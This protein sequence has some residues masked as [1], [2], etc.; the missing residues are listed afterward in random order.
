MHRRAY[1]TLIGVSAMMGLLAVL[2]AL[3]LD[4]RLVDPDGFLGPSWLRLPALVIGAFLADVV[5]RMVWVSRFQPKL[6]RGIAEDRIREHWTRERIT[7]VV[8]GLV[9][10][11][12]TYV[13]YR[14][15]KSFLPFVTTRTF[16]R[17]LHLLDQAL[18]FGREPAIV[19]HA[20]L[21]EGIV[22][23]ALSFIYLWFLP[24]VP[25]TLAAWLVW[26]RNISYGYWFVTAQVLAWTLGTA[27]YY[28]LPTLGPGF[29]YLWLYRDLSET[30][31]TTLM[32]SLWRGRLGVRLQDVSSAVQ[33]VAGF[34][35]LHTAITL[36]F[37]LMAQYTIRSRPV[38][39]ILWVN[40]GVTI[41]AT[42]YFGW[43]YIADDIGGVAIALVSFYLGGIATG[44]NFDRHGLASH[45]TTDSSVVPIDED[46]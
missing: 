14:N 34:A 16:D 21:G 31:T 23:H 43:H 15:L 4:K 36:L 22:A 27:S 42:L 37:A 6:M 41:L 18:F 29:E 2:T 35:S 40:F 9:C 19:L 8:L 13:S 1:A 30:G 12:V 44:Q 17:E 10:F 39:W 25:I 33:S 32:D 7:L 24:L 45:P 38:H 11:Y 20:V 3:A 26:S 46:A 5:P 28:A